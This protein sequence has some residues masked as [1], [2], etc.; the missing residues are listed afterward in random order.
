MCGIVEKKYW[1]LRYVVGCGL[2]LNQKRVSTTVAL[3]VNG[4]SFF[5]KRCSI[6]TMDCLSIRQCKLQYETIY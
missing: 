3:L 2:S 5:P 6:H 1:I 4:F